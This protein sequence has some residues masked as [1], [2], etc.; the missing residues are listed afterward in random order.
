MIKHKKKIHRNCQPI[1]TRVVLLT[2]GTLQRESINCNRGTPLVVVVVVLAAVV[3][4]VAGKPVIPFPSR[5]WQNV[6]DHV[7]LAQAQNNK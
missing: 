2:V 4:V 6:P 3:V 5:V 1:V 7:H